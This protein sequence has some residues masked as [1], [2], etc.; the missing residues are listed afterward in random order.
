M[1]K[2]IL[3]TFTFLLF[4]GAF[5]LSV[6]S[7]SNGKISFINR[8]NAKAADTIQNSQAYFLHCPDQSVIVVCGSGTGTCS[9]YGTCPQY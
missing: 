7:S 8:A 1:K 9:P 3:S 6:S 2:K 4:L 5:F